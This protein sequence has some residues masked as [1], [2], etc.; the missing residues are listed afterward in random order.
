MAGALGDTAESPKRR[1][2][3]EDAMLSPASH[4]FHNPFLNFVPPSLSE[5]LL[6]DTP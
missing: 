4:A 5:P 2:D 6:C 1:A 3:D